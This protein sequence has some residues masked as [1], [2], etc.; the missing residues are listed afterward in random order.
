MGTEADL[1][2][3]SEYMKEVRHHHVYLATDEPAVVAVAREAYSNHTFHSNVAG[4]QAAKTQQTRYT[5][6]SL[7]GLLQDLFALARADF[8]VRKGSFGLL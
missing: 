7:R 5:D 6:A 2:E 4:A 1:H 8:L 3:L